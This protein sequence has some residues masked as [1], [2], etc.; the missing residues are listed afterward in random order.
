MARIAEDLLLLL[1][2]KA[3]ARPEMD[4][5][6]HERVLTAAALLDLAHACRIPSCGRQ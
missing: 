5:A 4:R 2:D 1:L 6:R 3:S